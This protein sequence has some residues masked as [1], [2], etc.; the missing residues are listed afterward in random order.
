MGEKG[1]NELVGLCKEMYM[2]GVWPEDF[3]KVIMIPLQKK[4][5]AVECGDHRTISLISHAS[6]ILLK[7]L[8]RRIEAKTKDFIGRNQFGFRRGCGTRDAIGVMRVLCERSMEFGNDV[9]VCF[10]DFEKAFDRVNWVKMMEVLKSLDVDW[11]DR[12]MIYQLYIKQEA[13][14]RIADGD[15]E[16]GIIGRGVRQGCNP[17]SSATFNLCRDDDGLNVGRC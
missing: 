5:N 17:L 3:T 10:V 6:K 7:V 16:P 11:R 8:T 13:V 15:S 2:Q 9:Y 14:I 12:R 4:A 1:T